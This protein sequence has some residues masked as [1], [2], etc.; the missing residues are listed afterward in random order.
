MAPAGGTVLNGGNSAIGDADTGCGGVSRVY[1]KEQ[2]VAA[3]GGLA[4]S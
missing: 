2:I 3:W 1:D 4:P